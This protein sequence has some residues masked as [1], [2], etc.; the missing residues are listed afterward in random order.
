MKPK[1]YKEIAEKLAIRR[2][3]REKQLDIIIQRLMTVMNQAGL[4]AEISG[5]PKH[6]HSIYRK[7]VNKGVPFDLYMILEA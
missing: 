1:E 4:E 6:I 2:T 3:D 7:M 5:R